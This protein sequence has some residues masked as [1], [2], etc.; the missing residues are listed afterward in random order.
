M[1]RINLGADFVLRGIDTPVEDNDAASRGFV[2]T[3]RAG[4]TRTLT[5]YQSVADGTTPT[6]LTFTDATSSTQTG[7]DFATGRTTNATINGWL[8]APPAVPVAGELIWV[9]DIIIEGQADGTWIIPVVTPA[10]VSWLPPFQFS[11]D[12]GEQGP[13]GV[14]GEQTIYLYHTTSTNPANVQIPTATQGFAVANDRPTA[15]EATTLDGTVWAINPTDPPG[16]AD[17]ILI[18]TAVIERN[19]DN[20]AWVL[21]GTGWTPAVTWSG[22]R[23]RNG[24]DGAGSITLSGTAQ[25]IP[26]G[27]ILTADF[28][29]GNNRHF[30]FFN[31]RPTLS[32]PTTA[33]TLAIT[34]NGAQAV[35]AGIAPAA[36]TIPA[37][38][39]ITAGTTVIALDNDEAYTGGTLTVA[40][41]DIDRIVG[42]AD[43][44]ATAFDSFDV[45]SETAG[46]TAVRT[47]VAVTLA[48][49]TAAVSSHPL[50]DLGYYEVTD[51]YAARTVLVDGTSTA[52]V[53]ASRNAILIVEGGTAPG[54]YRAVDDLA[55][56]AN[57]RVLSNEFTYTP[58]GRLANLIDSVQQFL[59]N[60][61]AP[62][63]GGT[64]I[65]RIQDADDL[66]HGTFETGQTMTTLVAAAPITGTVVAGTATGTL[67]LANLR[68]TSET[69]AAGT[70]V[71]ADTFSFTIDNEIAYSAGAHTLAAADFT[72]AGGTAPTTATAFTP[73]PAEGETSF[74]LANFAVPTYIPNKEY[75]SGDEVK[76]ATSDGDHNIYIATNNT[77]TTPSATATDWRRVDYDSDI[78]DT[79]IT[80]YN[81]RHNIPHVEDTHTVVTE[82]IFN[83]ANR[84]NNVGQLGP[85]I[86]DADKDFAA[87][88][89]LAGTF[90]TIPGGTNNSNAPMIQARLG[91]DVSAT[92]FDSA[93]VNPPVRLALD[94]PAR[95][96][97]DNPLEV[98]VNRITRE[99]NVI[100][101]ASV[102]NSFRAAIVGGASFDNWSALARV[103]AT[104]RKMLYA[105]KEDAT[106]TSFPTNERFRH[107]TWVNTA[108]PIVD[109]TSSLP[110]P[111]ETFNTPHN[112]VVSFNSV[113]LILEN[114]PEGNLTNRPLGGQIIQP[115]ASDPLVFNNPPGVVKVWPVNITGNDA[116]NARFATRRLGI[117]YRNPTGSSLNNRIQGYEFTLPPE[118]IGNL[119]VPS[120]A[121]T[122]ATEADL[123]GMQ[124]DLANALQRHGSAVKAIVFQ[125]IPVDEN[126]GIHYPSMQRV[127]IGLDAADASSTRTY[128][129]ANPVE[130]YQSRPD[131]GPVNVNTDAAGTNRIQTIQFNE[132]WEHPANGNPVKVY[133][134]GQS[135]NVLPD[136]TFQYRLA[137]RLTERNARHTE[138][139]GLVHT[140]ASTYRIEPIG[141]D[142]LS[143]TAQAARVTEAVTQARG[144]NASSRYEF[145]LTEARWTGGNFAAD[146][147][148]ATYIGSGRDPL[149]TFDAREAATVLPDIFYR[150]D[151]FFNRDTRNYF[152]ANGMRSTGTDTDHYGLTAL[153]A[154][155]LATITTEDSNILVT[156]SGDR[157]DLRGVG[158]HF[159]LLSRITANAQIIL[160]GDL[161]E[162]VSLTTPQV[163]RLFVYTGFLPDRGPTGRTPPGVLAIDFDT[164]VRDNYTLL[165]ATDPIPP[166]T[167]VHNG[168]LTGAG[169]NGS[170]LGIADNSINT[171]RLQDDAVTTAKI[172]DANVT[173]DK[174]AD[175]AVTPAKVAPSTT[176]GQVLRTISDTSVTPAVN[177]VAWA[178]EAGGISNWSS[179]VTYAED[180]VVISANRI[181]QRTD[182]TIAPADARPEASTAGWREISAS[183][184]AGTPAEI[185]TGLNMNDGTVD[186]N[187]NLLPA[188]IARD[189]EIPGIITTGDGSELNITRGYDFATGTFQLNGQAIESTGQGNISVGGTTVG[190]VNIP[191]F[192][193]TQQQAVR[194]ERIGTTDTRRT[195]QMGTTG[196][197]TLV[198]VQTTGVGGTM[199]TNFM[200]IHGEPG[201]ASGTA[202]T[203]SRGQIQLS[204]NTTNTVPT[205]ATSSGLFFT[206][207]QRTGETQVGRLNIHQ[208]LDLISRVSLIGQTVTEQSFEA[209]QTA[210]TPAAD[211]TITTRTGTTVTYTGTIDTDRF[212]VGNTSVLG[213]EP[214]G[215]NP[216]SDTDTAVVTGIDTA[217]NT[218]TF[219]AVPTDWAAGDVLYDATD[220]N[221]N[222]AFNPTLNRFIGTTRGAGGSRITTLVLPG[223][224]YDDN[225][226]YTGTDAG[227]YTMQII[228]ENPTTGTAGVDI[229]V[230]MRRL[231]DSQ[232]TTADGSQVANANPLPTYTFMNL[233]PGIN[234]NTAG[235]SFNAQGELVLQ[236]GAET[237]A[238]DIWRTHFTNIAEDPTNNLTGFFV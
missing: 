91:V 8:P 172:L 96:G 142:N 168:T 189:A 197:P 207:T 7:I 71:V 94:I 204:L 76:I 45:L 41:M 156:P 39:R 34:G 165:E 208:N 5:R 194:M 230:R 222:L 44:A 6:A 199:T 221:L 213:A 114:A 101:G 164:E 132:I 3:S 25:D 157:I 141:W 210:T 123:N 125:Q 106:L 136:D 144:A 151:G 92:E 140:N 24:E 181:W 102:P 215:T 163:T 93:P 118:I 212:T 188:T 183:T 36:G 77:T 46:E 175:D 21:Q 205:G 23:G 180:D 85:Q 135:G 117:T 52:V 185:L 219:D 89:S 95:S 231:L 238:I 26:I 37:G 129:A 124:N 184:G 20:D 237:G 81:T 216:G 83:T 147:G 62:T 182:A 32:T 67:E 38:T 115:N 12:R 138:P 69:I 202:G 111:R 153:Q 218:I 99:Q 27:T 97:D 13:I 137:L 145:R 119:G 209:L 78:V 233:P 228:V 63:P 190:G 30:Q 109:S 9:T 75:H 66:F 33:G 14:A 234:S 200:S 86:A 214:V 42:T 196:A 68:P 169:V 166:S 98:E 170:P 60:T 122:T 211:I 43:I 29:G 148:R 47:G 223:V 112:S 131:G 35:F 187:D 232:R 51:G 48:E 103:G 53:I 130:G 220:A 155:A 158:G 149:T 176:V 84:M 203:D 152:V 192:V 206:N 128:M 226:R 173:T 31:G 160:P 150:L 167:V 1:P 133:P 177:E 55:D 174:I 87:V 217:T 17:R 108:S 79:E 236:T 80:A 65:T 82:D 186:I 159:K 100:P 19:A 104:N 10:T 15:A 22:P 40:A 18:T 229:I 120:Q 195:F 193:G 113:H 57:Q 72:V 143:D 201:A 227:D 146:N 2:N 59:T 110:T 134:Q 224:N 28:G 235:N 191:I 198:E 116:I 58:T 225:F 73:I 90:V 74:I 88:S 105:Q 64:G 161:V 56:N 54:I 126:H 139:N 154:E 121:H 11:G 162:H 49:F 61:P 4:I 171:A 179:T 50:D 70:T 127:T 178:D 16:V 107:S